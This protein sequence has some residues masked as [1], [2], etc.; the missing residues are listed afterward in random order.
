[1]F[2][3][4]FETVM[5]GIMHTGELYLCLVPLIVGPML[6]VSGSFEKDFTD[7]GFMAMLIGVALAGLKVVYLGQIVHR[8]K[9][10]MDMISFLFWL[11]LFILPVL[12]PWAALNGELFT[13]A[14]WEHKLNWVAW[15]FLIVVSLMGGLRAYTINLTVK[16]SSALTKTTADIFTQAL[17]IYSSLWIFQTAASPGLHSGIIITIAGFAIY[18]GLKYKETYLKVNEEW[19]EGED[20]VPFLGGGVNIHRDRVTSPSKLADSARILV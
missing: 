19:C 17:S 5:L 4:V 3:I 14:Q 6:T 20:G 7:V 2:V 15:A 8:L 10:E 16:H 11:D 18:M 9:E 1:V 13:V 12:L